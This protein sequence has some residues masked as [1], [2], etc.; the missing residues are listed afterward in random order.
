MAITRRHIAK[1]TVEIISYL[2]VIL[3]GLTALDKAVQFER[4]YTELGK[5]PFLM[6]Y[7]G[8]VAWGTPAVEAVVTAALIIGQTQL[9][10]LYASVSLM[11]LFTSYIYLLLNY[12]YY[13]PCLCS[14]A[15][16]NLTWEQHLLFN[17]AF[18]ALACIAV[19]LKERQLKTHQNNKP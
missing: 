5:S 18:L 6:A 13:T 16:E 19:V 11:S 9:W 4:F 14:A 7:Q 3:F 2:L 12:S 17:S 1:G 15:L 10:G 8:W